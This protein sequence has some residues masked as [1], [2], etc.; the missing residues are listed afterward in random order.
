MKFPQILFP[1]FLFFR[2]N[3]LLFFQLCLM[4]MFKHSISECWCSH[5]CVSYRINNSYSL[6]IFA[7]PLYGFCPESF[8]CKLQISTRPRLGKFPE[9]LIL[10]LRPQ[11]F[12]VFP[13]QNSFRKA[14]CHFSSRQTVDTGT[15]VDQR[16]A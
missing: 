14:L 13:N 10:F 8:E 4:K 6:A 16:A 15:P 9:L 2:N 3:A 1:P 12:T 7:L 11:L 5:V